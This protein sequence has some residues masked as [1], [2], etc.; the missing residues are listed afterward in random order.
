MAPVYNTSISHIPTNCTFSHR[1]NTSVYDNLLRDGTSGTENYLYTGKS[2]AWIIQPT[3]TCW[4]KVES[5]IQNKWDPNR[6]FYWLILEFISSLFYF[7]SALILIFYFLYS[8]VRRMTR[9]T[10]EQAHHLNNQPF[11]DM[12]SPV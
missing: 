11:S 6:C 7:N 1:D 4:Y 10:S 2:Q 5:A 3:A 12:P 8:S 9:V